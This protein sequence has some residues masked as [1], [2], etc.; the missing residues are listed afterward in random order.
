[1]IFPGPWVGSGLGQPSIRAQTHALE[2]FLAG[3]YP[4]LLAVEFTL[5]LTSLLEM[6]NPLLSRHFEQFNIEMLF[7]FRGFLAL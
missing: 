3:H 6:G 2:A 7:M 4:V 1:M 5:S